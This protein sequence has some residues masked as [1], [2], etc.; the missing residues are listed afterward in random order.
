MPLAAAKADN[1]IATRIPLI[2]RTA[3][4]RLC[5]MATIRLALPMALHLL[6]FTCNPPI[7]SPQFA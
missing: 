7:A 1:P 2:V 3:V 5:A 6:E 4:H